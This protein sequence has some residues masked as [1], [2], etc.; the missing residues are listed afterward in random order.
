MERPQG[1]GALTE[2]REEREAESFCHRTR[3]RIA[4]FRFSFFSSIRTVH[5]VSGW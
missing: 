5:P 3:R 4:D 2:G 1:E